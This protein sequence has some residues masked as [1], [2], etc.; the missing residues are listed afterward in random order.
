MCKISNLLIYSLYA[1]Y[2]INKQYVSLKG[3]VVI[4]EET[5]NCDDIYIVYFYGDDE[6][7][8]ETDS[9]T[10]G[11]LPYE[12]DVPLAGITKLKIK[13]VRTEKNSGNS[14]I[15]ISEARFYK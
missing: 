6:Y 15:A 8:T 4:P 5:K 9:M 3:N 14:S 1:E 12:F 11:S 7:I 13:I 2:Y 10:M